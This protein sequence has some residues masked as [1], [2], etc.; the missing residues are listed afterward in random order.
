MLY[1]LHRKII[2]T[3]L[4][5]NRLLLLQS[6]DRGTETF[7]LNPGATIHGLQE[8]EMQELPRPDGILKLSQPSLSG[9]HD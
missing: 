9:L 2:R 8:Q 3:K 4:T 7:M 1:N 5:Q 6:K